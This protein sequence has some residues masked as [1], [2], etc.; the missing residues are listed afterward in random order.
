MQI[1]TVRLYTDV[2]VRYVQYVVILNVFFLH[3]LKLFLPFCYIIVHLRRRM[4]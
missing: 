1:H 2:H 3:A 4:S